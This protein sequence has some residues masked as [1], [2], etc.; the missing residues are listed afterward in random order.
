MIVSYVCAIG[1]AVIFMLYMDGAIGVMMLAFL[2]LMPV[3]S[4]AATLPLRKKISITL[5]LPD[6]AAKQRT[7]SAVIL[8]EKDT[9]LPLPFLRL[10]L[11]ADAHF[12]PVSPN[13]DA[14][15]PRPDNTD[16]LSGRRAYAKWRKRRKT[17]LTPDILP[18]CLS[19]GSAR[20]AEYRIPL[21]TRYCG[22]GT[23]YLENLRLSDYFGMF[24]FRI[25][26]SCRETLLVTP[27]I[28]ELK[29]NA[30][31][32]RSV[33]T[34][35][36]AADE[37]SESTPQH[38]ASAMP[39]YEHRDYIPGESLKRINWQLSAK[40]RHL[41][42]RQDEPVALARLSVVLDFRRDSRALPEERR[43]MA[44]EQLIETALGFLMLCAKY[45]YPCKLS[46]ADANGQ[47]SSIS[48]DSPD[49]LAVEAVTLLRGGCRSEEELGSLP[50]LPPELMQESSSLLMF[51]T[52]H[53]GADTAAALARFPSL[54]YLLVPEQDADS[55]SVPKNGSLWLVTSEHKLIQAGGE[56]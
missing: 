29:A 24:S 15:P 3:L 51:F 2:I 34:A 35:V 42:V 47:W 30:E 7:R 22:A 26:L 38:S 14:L 52:T 46:Y 55:F 27:D 39:G 56:V 49:Q 20:S 1:I 33:S 50:M 10:T 17:Q 43:L 18:L 6:S 12:A 21:T 16:S 40:R 4:L 44:E 36:A 37:E 9:V 13:A 23:V 45:S 11:R 31:L 19:L 32:F 8:L 25:S 5:K 28:P 41:M 48:I 53:T 54:L